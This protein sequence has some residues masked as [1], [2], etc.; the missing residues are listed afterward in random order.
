MKRNVGSDSIRHPLVTLEFS[1][2][3]DDFGGIIAAMTASQ[4]RFDR[5]RMGRDQAV[6]IQA[7][8]S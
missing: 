2:G 7:A 3:P 1:C 8:A 5:S 6:H 4:N